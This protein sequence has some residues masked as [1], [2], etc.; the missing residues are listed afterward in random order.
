MRLWYHEN[1]RVFQDRLI[2]DED[3]DWFRSL[4]G[5]RMKADF[6]IDFNEVV[7]EPVLYGDFVAQTAE[8]A[9]QEIDDV[10]LVRYNQ[11]FY[12]KMSLIFL[13]EKTFR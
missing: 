12:L 7:Q 3:R 13:D 4:L 8:K 11:V 2:N 10:P 9:Y 1:C 6:N 5:E